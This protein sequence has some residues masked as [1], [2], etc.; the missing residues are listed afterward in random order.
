[1]PT[2]RLYTLALRN[3]RWVRLLTVIMVI[4]KRVS[5]GLTWISLFCTPQQLR[6]SFLTFETRATRGSKIVLN[7]HPL[8][9]GFG[10]R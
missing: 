1:M 4:I 7:T 8:A 9:C 3:T 10:I 5:C 6:N 2:S